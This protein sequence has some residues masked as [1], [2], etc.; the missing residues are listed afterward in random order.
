MEFIDKVNEVCDACEKMPFNDQL[1]GKIR[2]EFN[3][4]NYLP[5]GIKM[6]F[7]GFFQEYMRQCTGWRWQ[8]G[9]HCYLDEVWYN[10]MKS[11]EYNPPHVHNS[12][13]GSEGMS[14][15]LML[16]KPKTYGKEFSKEE[17]PTNGYLNLI[18]GMQDSL[19]ASMCQTDMQVG[20][21]YIFPYS[22]VHSVNPFN[23][24]KEVRRTLSYNCNIYKD[25]ELTNPAVG[26]NI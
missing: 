19:A 5:D 18:C 1:A 4:T 21:F 10:D 11:G 3:I 6:E 22:L 14:S 20:D 7:L 17:N 23:G 12:V 16:K 25:K 13:V 26:G 15:V 8:N 9:S 24:T 2:K